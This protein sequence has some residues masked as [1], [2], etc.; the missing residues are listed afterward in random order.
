MATF[1]FIMTYVVV[2]FIAWV[3][4]ITMENGRRRDSDGEE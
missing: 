2:A 3:A 4:G 1:G